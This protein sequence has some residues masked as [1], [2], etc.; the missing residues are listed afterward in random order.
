MTRL[1]TYCV[2]ILAC[3]VLAESPTARAEVN[4]LT[5]NQIKAAYLYNFAKFVEWPAA[6]L[7]A[8]APLVIGILG[9]GP[10]GEAQSALSGRSAKGHRVQVRQIGRPEEAASCQ[11]LFVAGSERH[12]LK[13]IL[14]ALPATGVL[15]V[16]DIRN[17]CSTGGMI[18]L[19]P[20]GDKVQFEINLGTAERAGLKLS[21]Q[22]L[23]LAL[24]VYE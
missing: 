14:R 9:K 12:R 3:L 13:E 22:M 18:G 15:T 8:G 11:I 7:P 17:F 2:L 4:Q 21:S 10:L 5:E 24:T 19:A 6:A 16:S 23:K 1:P 20:Q